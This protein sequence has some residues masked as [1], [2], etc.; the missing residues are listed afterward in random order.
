MGKIHKLYFEKTETGY[1]I[2]DFTGT[3]IDTSCET[4]FGELE[5][6]DDKFAVEISNEKFNGA[7]MLFLIETKV[8]KSTTC[9]VYM[10]VN[11][12]KDDLSEV[13]LSK[14]FQDLFGE[15]PKTIFYRKF[16]AI[17]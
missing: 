15:F 9:G 11:S 8:L 16:F 10:G 5:T 14:F 6:L 2:I 3:S 17:R 4:F 12:E 1:Q 13:R 7:K